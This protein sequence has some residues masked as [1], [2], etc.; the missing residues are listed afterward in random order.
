MEPKKVFTRAL[1]AVSVLSLLAVLCWLVSVATLSDLA[2]SDAAG[3][4]YS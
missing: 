4:G 1:V 3:N 2:G